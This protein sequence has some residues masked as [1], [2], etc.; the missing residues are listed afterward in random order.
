MAQ[1]HTR[2]RG[3]GRL[4]VNIDFAVTPCLMAKSLL[5]GSCAN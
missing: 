4:E 1:E 2:G 5:D 3:K